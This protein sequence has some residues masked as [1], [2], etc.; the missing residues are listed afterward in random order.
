MKLYVSTEGYAVMA[1]RHPAFKGY[2]GP[3]FSADGNTWTPF[4]LDDKKPP[5]I[6]R[7]IVRRSDRDTTD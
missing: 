4:W 5:A 6:A 2:S 3:H 7:V 1:E